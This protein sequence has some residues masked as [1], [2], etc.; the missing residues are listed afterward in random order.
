VP[1]CGD[2]TFL[3]KKKTVTKLKRQKLKEYEAL[4]NI[5]E[6]IGEVYI[7]NIVNMPSYWSRF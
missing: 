4:R 6:L 5:S 1:V 7:A 3:S 2:E